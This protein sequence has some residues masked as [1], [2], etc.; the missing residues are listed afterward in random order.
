VSS[1]NDERSKLVFVVHGRNDRLR[2][3]MY[4]FLRA[5]GLNPLEW[6]EIKEQTEGLNPYIGEILETGFR[7]AQAAVVLLTGDDEARLK[8]EFRGK[9]DPADEGVLRPQ[10]RPN[11]L[12]E[13]G[14]AMARL[15]NATVL[16]QIGTL[17]G[18]SDMA[19]RNMIRM[20]NSRQS[21]TELARALQKAGCDI[22][23]E[24]NNRWVDA[25]NFACR[26]LRI[27]AIWAFC[28]HRKPQLRSSR[29]QC[30]LILRIAI[31]QNLVLSKTETLGFI[32]LDSLSLFAPPFW[33]KVMREF[34][35]LSLCTCLSAQDQVSAEST[36]DLIEKLRKGP[37]TAQVLSTLKM[38]PV[39]PGDS[40]PNLKR[41]SCRR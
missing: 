29:V 31:R 20:D 41:R 39:D 19:G 1:R 7:K 14:S 37:V 36:R 9:L 38:R 35:I 10:P 34:A 11:I 5:L 28:L 26:L 21:R 17:R 27:L 3:A 30:H 24:S 2:I 8:S 25:G 4:E 32:G 22:E 33:E 15:P 18:M 16:V 6:T 40:G 12:F 23:F 13:A